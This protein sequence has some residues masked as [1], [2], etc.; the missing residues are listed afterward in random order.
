MSDRRWTF[1]S[2]HGHVLVCLARNPDMRLRDIADAVG[3]TERSTQTIVN[4]LEEAGYV[5]KERVGRR[6][7]YRLNSDLPLRHP[8]E[9]HRAVGELLDLIV[10]EDSVTG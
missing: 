7:H 2:N 3:I 5:V 8:L 1:L 6:N 10:G 9:E 4:D